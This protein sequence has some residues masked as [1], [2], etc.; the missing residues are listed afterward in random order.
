M[1]TEKN[2]GLI[3]SQKTSI[4]KNIEE[5]QQILVGE[6]ANSHKVRLK[7]ENVA[8]NLIRIYSDLEMGTDIAVLCRDIKNNIPPQRSLLEQEYL[9]YVQK[10][11]AKL[12]EVLS[13]KE[14]YAEFVD[15]IHP[16]Q[17]VSPPQL[18]NQE[19]K[20]FLENILRKYI[21]PKEGFSYGEESL[22]KKAD[23][24]EDTLRKKFDNEQLA[25]LIRFARENK[26]DPREY[27]AFLSAYV[28]NPITGE[29]IERG[30]KLPM[31][32]TEGEIFS[33]GGADWYFEGKKHPQR[34][35]PTY[36][37]NYFK[38]Q[39]KKDGFLE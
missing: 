33:V 16:T 23:E 31:K 8:A 36:D 37:V 28:S 18:A 14:R 21:I 22:F 13:K 3:G 38:K 4:E 26:L 20:K 25:E 11:T 39:W 24:F 10:I 6:F 19:H 12:N 15:R 29:Q 32:L 30:D 17:I 9:P 35:E 1:Y 2:S 27:V 34:L 7:L 5:I